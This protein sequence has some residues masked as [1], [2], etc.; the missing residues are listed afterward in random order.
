MLDVARKQAAVDVKATGEKQ[1][2]AMQLLAAKLV[3]LKDD[4]KVLSE[5][6]LFLGLFF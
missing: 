5:A 4:S 6:C 1:L 2:D 3:A